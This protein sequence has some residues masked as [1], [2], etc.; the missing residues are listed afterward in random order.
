[1]ETILQIVLAAA[2]LAAVG[3]I[4][5]MMFHGRQFLPDSVREEFRESQRRRWLGLK[6]I[7]S[8]PIFVR[9][10]VIYAV[11]QFGIALARVFL[12]GPS[13]PVIVG[14]LVSVGVAVYALGLVI[15]ARRKED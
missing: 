13:W 2:L 9:V 4:G 8:N 15:L 6:D 14:L 5:W 1:M 7:Y 10:F 3:A 12:R 11:V